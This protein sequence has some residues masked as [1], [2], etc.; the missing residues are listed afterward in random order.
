M[1]AESQSD[2]FI[3]D[4]ILRLQRFQPAAPEMC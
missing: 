4:A 3:G 1:K 2:F